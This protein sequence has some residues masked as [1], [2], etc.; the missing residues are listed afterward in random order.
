LPYILAS[1]KLIVVAMMLTACVDTDPGAYGP[2][3]V[4]VAPENAHALATADLDGDGIADVVAVAPGTADVVSGGSFRRTAL[5]AAGGDA[6]TLADFDGDGVLDV[7]ISKRE[8]STSS[9]TSHGVTTTIQAANMVVGDFT[10]DGKPDLF[11]LGSYADTILWLNMTMPGGAPSFARAPASGSGRTF[12]EGVATDV[13]GDGWTDVV[14][15]SQGAAYAMF[16]SR[17]M[18][19]QPV[20]IQLPGQATA[21][22]VADFD[23]DGRND[24][25]FTAAT[26]VGDRSAIV[27]LRNQTETGSRTPSYVTAATVLLRGAPS[28][29]LGA[30]LDGDQLPELVVSG[31]D[32]VTGLVW[33]SHNLGGTFDEP[34]VFATASFAAPAYPVVA[35]DFDRDG[36]IDIVT[37]GRALSLLSRR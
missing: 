31:N 6:V 15:R 21:L 16:N 2:Y 5:G 11:E 33:I 35:A 4:V 1:V 9:I 14:V 13:D 25:A 24:L 20:Q 17:G 28:F 22:W 19:G 18:F 37:G 12:I 30:D 8:D 29:A 10:G 32:D 36:R 23:H 7:A 27:V 26:G 34:A 3:R